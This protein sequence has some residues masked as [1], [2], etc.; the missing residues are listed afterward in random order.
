VL[1]PV[2]GG[3]GI[4]FVVRSQTIASGQRGPSPPPSHDASHAPRGPGASPKAWVTAKKAGNLAQRLVEGE[5]E[6][7]TDTQHTLYFIAELLS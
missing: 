5:G 7:K 2:L 4:T 1:A 3:R 6:H